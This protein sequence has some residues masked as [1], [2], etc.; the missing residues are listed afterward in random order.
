M[1]L[2][3]LMALSVIFA[4]LVTFV[5]GLY[6]F[7]VGDAAGAFES[8]FL[9]LIGFG[10]LAYGRALFRHIK[11]TAQPLRE[12]LGEWGNGDGGFGG[13][14]KSEEEKSDGEE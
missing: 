3:V 13:E 5:G 9:T 12:G 7:F 1:F 2:S 6:L 8:V 11:N 14:R 4:G 10:L